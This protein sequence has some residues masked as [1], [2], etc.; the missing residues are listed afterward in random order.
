MHL[1][2]KFGYVSSHSANGS[3]SLHNLV[4]NKKSRDQSIIYWP[5]KK[6]ICTNEGGGSVLILRKPGFFLRSSGRL[7]TA[8]A[9]LFYLHQETPGMIPYPISPFG[10]AHFDPARIYIRRLH[11]IIG[12][13]HSCKYN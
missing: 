2:A 4:D 12:N 13:L 8:A 9:E 3:A 7:N 10:R 1:M 6:Y 5:D 11:S